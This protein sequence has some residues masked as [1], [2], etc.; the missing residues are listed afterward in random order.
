MNATRSALIGPHS[1]MTA[2]RSALAKTWAIARTELR[3]YLSSTAVW[4]SLIVT[5]IFA[6]WTSDLGNIRT[7]EIF[8]GNSEITSILLSAF[9]LTLLI[10]AGIARE[11]R[12]SFDDVW[13]SLPVRNGQQYWGKVLGAIGSAILFAMGLFALL[14]LVWL[15]VGTVWTAATTSVVSAYVAQTAGL[16]LFSVGLSG[17]LRGAVSNLRLRYVLGLLLIV[18]LAI[19]QVLGIGFNAPWAVLLS[20]YMVGGVPYSDSLLWGVWPW[21]SMAVPH[22]AFQVAFS[23]L[24]LFLGRVMY[25]RRRDPGQ[26]T[27]GAKVAIAFLIVAMIGSAA[28]YVRQWKSVRATID[29]QLTY[30]I[31]PL[32]MLTESGQLV[33]QFAPIDIQLSSYDLRVRLAEDG[34]LQIRAALELVG[35]PGQGPWPLTLHHQWEVLQVL[36]DGIDDWSRD[37][38]FI[39]VE[40]KP[41]EIPRQI[42]VEYKGRPF[43]WD[44]QRGTVNP[45]Q[46]MSQRGGYLSPLLAW[47]PIPG[48][49]RLV[50]P[51]VDGAIRWARVEN[52][53]LVPQPVPMRLRWEGPGHLEVVS[54]LDAISRNATG[55]STQVVFQG[56]SDGMSIFAGPM[57]GIEGTVPRLETSATRMESS[58]VG[59]EEAAAR[60]EAPGSPLERSRLTVIGPSSLVYGAEVLEK[61]YEKM[62]TFYE[63][64]IGRPFPKKPVVAIPGWLARFYNP[65]YYRLTVSPGPSQ[66]IR[67]LTHLGAKPVV[68]ESALVRAIRAAERWERNSNPQDLLDATSAIGNALLQSTWGRPYTF[69]VLYENQVAFGLAQ[70]TLLRWWEHVLGPEAFIEVRQRIR[71]A[72]AIRF[73]NETERG[74]QEVLETL[75]DIEERHGEQA[76]RTLLGL[77][78]DFMA[79][80]PITIDDFYRLVAAATSEDLDDSLN[81][82]RGGGPLE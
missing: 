16:L 55:E 78:Y 10:T 81:P 26:S 17:F 27:S 56:V 80:Q 14:P 35:D 58:S 29:D 61:P 73:P 1:A 33:S 3:L 34:H 39:W 82:V 60:L 15:A 42:I 2:P 20:P 22:V 65:F 70:Y 71:A 67:V 48:Q 52:D 64:L 12:E 79:T 51:V 32:W 8:L 28:M 53:P 4:V 11:E 7:I 46:F 24:L 63:E 38:N 9:V 54:N 13:N 25:E 18:L 76:V 23:A 36:G 5:L 21:T 49:R 68:S 41:D 66:F 19:A 59:L 69:Q 47:Y 37:G 62:I 6:V 77:V 31:H 75:F 72:S 44:W 40:V 50:T 30:D 57:I 43:L 74:V 45:M